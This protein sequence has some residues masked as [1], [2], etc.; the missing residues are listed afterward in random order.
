MASRDLNNDLSS[1]IVEAVPPFVPRKRVVQK[2]VIRRNSVVR[3]LALVTMTVIFLTIT[4]GGFAQGSSGT[5]A[6]A[7]A[8]VEKAIAALKADKTKSTGRL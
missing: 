8:M 5:A 2:R 1:V 4:G 6:E 7:K 3:A